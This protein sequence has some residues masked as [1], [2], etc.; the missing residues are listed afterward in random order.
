M[1]DIDQRIRENR[2][3][4]RRLQNQRHTVF[5]AQKLEPGVNPKVHSEQDLIIAQILQNK[6]RILDIQLQ[7]LRAEKQPGYNIDEATL[8]KEVAEK[9]QKVDELEKLLTK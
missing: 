1:D 6:E 3:E 8:E 2:E 7:F 5:S 9:Q 4:Y